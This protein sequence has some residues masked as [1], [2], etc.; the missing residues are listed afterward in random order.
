MKI[1]L[2]TNVF[3]SGIFFGGPPSQILQSWR[4][5]QI[6]IVLTEQILEE[7]QRVGNEL[8][9]KYFSINIEPII[10]L[11]TIFGDFVET[12]G[13]TETI[14]EDPDDNKFIEC[15]IASQS[16]LIVSGDKHLLK[17]S[18]YKD[19]EVLT[20]RQFVDNYIK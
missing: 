14:C 1:V 7:Y 17:I 10:E 8:S 3:I 2:D 20:P 18:G 15:A 9:T 16:K 5:S 11:F 12:K 13:I 19:I 6:Q 4:K